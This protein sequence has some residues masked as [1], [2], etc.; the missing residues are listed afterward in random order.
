MGDVDVDVEVRGKGAAMG[1]E[2][3]SRAHTRVLILFVPAH[4]AYA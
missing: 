4:D 3:P 2:T 1:A